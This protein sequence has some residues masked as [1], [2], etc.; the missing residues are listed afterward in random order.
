MKI[1]MNKIIV[2]GASGAVKKLVNLFVLNRIASV[3]PGFSPRATCRADIRQIAPPDM[4]VTASIIAMKI[5]QY[6]V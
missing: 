6:R 2:I 4:D 3:R 1:P 5:M